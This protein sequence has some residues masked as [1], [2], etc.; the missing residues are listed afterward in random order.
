[1]P[2]RYLAID[3]GEKFIGLALG[4][5]TPSEGPAVVPIN[6][7]KTS[8]WS[9]A[10]SEIV[11]VIVNSKID[12]IVLGNPLN[13]SGNETAV[14]LKVHKFKR[15]LEGRVRCPVTLV[16]EFFS[17]RDAKLENSAY[18]GVSEHSRA[19]AVILLSYFEKINQNNSL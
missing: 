5:N 14:S 19:A 10:V 18:A 3:W 17:T 2:H 13:E 4:V 15:L 9:V 1:M 8:N 11:S 7:V 6:E 16:N 12:S